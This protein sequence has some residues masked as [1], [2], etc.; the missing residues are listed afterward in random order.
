MKK[1]DK[2]YIE[3]TNRWIKSQVM[4]IKQLEMSKKYSLDMIKCYKE[5]ADLDA[6]SIML[7]TKSLLYV[8]DEITKYCK[9]N[10]IDTNLIDKV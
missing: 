4:L 2:N 1:K 5:R 10:D 6:K 8:I 7:E 3:S 9:E